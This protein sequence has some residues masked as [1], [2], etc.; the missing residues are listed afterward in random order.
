MFNDRP[1][2]DIESGISHLGLQQDSSAQPWIPP[3]KDITQFLDEATQDMDEGQLIH[4]QSFTL[5]D[6]MTAIEVMDPRMD[7]GM[8]L[9]ENERIEFDIHQSLD[10]KQALWIM[11]R[12][13]NCE[14]A[15]L[16]GHSLAQTV[17]T[18]IY[19]HHI[20]EL[21]DQPPPTP[22]TATLAQ[23][24]QAVVKAY[25]LTTVRCCRY[26]WTEMSSG[27]VYEEEDF[28]TNLFGLSLYEDI[29]MDMDVFNDLRC[30]LRLLT[31]AMEKEANAEWAETLTALQERLTVREAFLKALMY[32]SQPRCSHIKQAETALKQILKLP[33]SGLGSGL[34]VP[35]AFDPN[36]N[37]KLTTQAPPRPVTLP[38]D[39]DAYTEF[40]QLIQRL[41]NICNV[42]TYPSVASLMNY[43]AHFAGSKPYPDAL[44]R[45]KLNSL[46]FADGHVFGRT[47]VHRFLIDS[48]MDISN[49]PP[50]WFQ[51]DQVDNEAPLMTMANA[52]LRQF[53]DQQAALPFMDFFKVQC[54]NR[55]R[56]RRLLCKVLNDW[57]MLQN[58]A[59]DIDLQFH[60][61]EAL[62]ET[63]LYHLSQW[64]Y[65][66]KLTI[67]ERIL[68]LGFELELYGQHEFTTIYWYHW[69][70]QSVLSNYH[71]HMHQ[72]DD[73]DEYGQYN[74]ALN[75]AKRDMSLGLFKLILAMEKSQQLKH[76]TLRFHNAKT[77][78]MHRLKPFVHMTS[79]PFQ[80][81]EQ[82]LQ[83]TNTDHLTTDILLDSAVL[84]FANARDVLKQLLKAPDTTSRSELCYEANRKELLSMIRVCVANETVV[85][86]LRKK[87]I[88]CK[89]EF[90]YHPWWATI[91][92]SN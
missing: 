35:G 22:P 89:M 6:A 92:T 1:I 66:M 42:T 30:A 65:M 55:A 9:P 85:L 48:I 86:Q 60:D 37:R 40:I 13:L 57:E 72:Q 45:S 70:V 38:S 12:L 32:L 71:Q 23:T 80:P 10:P 74:R 3:W 31:D 39:M 16:S 87:E 15:W 47:P 52:N 77:Q 62:N 33:L 83:D 78:F 56:Q 11:D 4:L 63:P 75:G 34:P 49:P 68:L 61:A 5:F 90:K 7:T 76:Q 41:D 25:I 91:L 17:Y 54:H 46:F 50:Q 81:F 51:A 27:N 43:F 24:M 2:Q 36:I 19:F 79:P 84:D 53:L 18:S 21:L 58:E 73:K 20:P 28:T 67:M 88:Q 14:M 69:Y 8:I 44:S 26:I 29:I 82:F 64:V 59:H